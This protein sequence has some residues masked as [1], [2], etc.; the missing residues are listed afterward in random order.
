MTDR[1]NAVHLLVNY[2]QAIAEKAAM[3][4][5]QDYTVEIGDAID[6]IITAAVKETLAQL[7]QQQEPELNDDNDA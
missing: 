5:Q 3:P 4:W 7:E 1:D 6:H 2:L